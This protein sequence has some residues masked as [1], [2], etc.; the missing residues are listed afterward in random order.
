MV[1]REALLTTMSV[2]YFTNMRTGLSNLLSACS[3]RNVKLNIPCETLLPYCYVCNR[4]LF[5]LSLEIEMA[6]KQEF[7]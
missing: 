4:C 6:E 2:M 1:I 3:I 5:S 7:L